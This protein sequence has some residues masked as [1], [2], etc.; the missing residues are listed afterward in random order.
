MELIC[1]VDLL[2]TVSSR[3]DGEEEKDVCVAT[4]ELTGC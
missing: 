3:N 4:V 2:F 1:E